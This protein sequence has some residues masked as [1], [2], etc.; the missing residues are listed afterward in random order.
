[1]KPAFE[2]PT[3]RLKR[4]TESSRLAGLSDFG[5][6]GIAV[7]A[8]L[9]ILAVLGTFAWMATSGL[10]SYYDSVIDLAT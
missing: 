3:E 4:V 9:V 1:M 8:G 2:T 6:L 10:T 5:G 7:V